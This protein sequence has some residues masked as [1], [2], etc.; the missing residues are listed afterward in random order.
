MIAILSLSALW[1]LLTE[2]FPKTHDASVHLIRLYLLDEQVRAGNLF[3]RWLLDLMT[4]YG[5]PT[6]NFYAPLIYI[7]AETFHLGGV[8]LA[9]ALTVL[10]VILIV[11]AGWGMYFLASDLYAAG[12]RLGHWAGLAAAV[13]Y[14]YT[15]YLL[16]N[17]YV[18]GALA[19]LLAQALLP[20]I[21]WCVT[22]IF[23]TQTPLRYTIGAA[24][25]FGAVA[26]G[27]NITLLLLPLLLGPYLLLLIFAIPL[28]RN[29]QIR[30]IGR[31]TG[32]SLIAAGATAF[33]W[34]PLIAERS[35]LSAQAFNAPVLEEHVW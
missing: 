31:L 23:T 35:L 7:I 19:E 13:V 18:R 17:L 5:Y 32:W 12:G 28:D 21:F 8:A 4:G 15:P 3:P 2:G 6:F 34:L 30:R 20:W 11:A 9:Y 29:E 16:V 22:R 26:L 24:A 33:F 1:P 14:I 25:L 10:M 27:H